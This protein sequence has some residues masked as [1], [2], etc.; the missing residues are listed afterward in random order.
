MSATQRQAAERAIRQGEYAHTLVAGVLGILEKI[1]A[2]QKRVL[3][4][5]AAARAQA[6]ASAAERRSG[7][8]AQRKEH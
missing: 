4:A 7:I 6:V 1:I 5:D 2:D 3:E 8:P